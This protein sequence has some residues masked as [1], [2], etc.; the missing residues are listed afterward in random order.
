M[1]FSEFL[2]KS[3]GKD[4]ALAENTEVVSAGI[5]QAIF[6]ILDGDRPYE[7]RKATIDRVCANCLSFSEGGGRVVV[8][9]MAVR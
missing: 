5:T 8:M 6:S 1:Q 3:N 7:D 2:A 9:I 4:R